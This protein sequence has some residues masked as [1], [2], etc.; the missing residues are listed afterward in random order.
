MSTAVLIVCETSRRWAT[1]WRRAQGG[2]QPAGELVACR[3][4]SECDV[5]LATHPA[6]FVALEVQTEQLKEQLDWLASLAERFPFARA[7]ALL[8]EPLAD[9]QGV[10]LEAGALA[11]IDSPRRL[12]PAVELWRAHRGRAPQP[13]QS[14]SE[15]IWSRLPWRAARTTTDTGVS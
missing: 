15:Q 4:L 7:A 12:A 2:G 14:A 8:D 1:F 3:S 11:V 9:A 5:I 6:S 13:E 10:L